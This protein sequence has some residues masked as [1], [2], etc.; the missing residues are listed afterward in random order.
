MYKSW[1]VH[2]PRQNAS[3]RGAQ[4][5]VKTGGKILSHFCIKNGGR[6]PLWQANWAVLGTAQRA[7]DTI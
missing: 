5:G 6:F 4:Q 2:I 1:K 3:S 7:V